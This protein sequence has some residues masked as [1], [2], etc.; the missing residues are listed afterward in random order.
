MKEFDTALV[1]LEEDE[2]QAMIE[3][4][5]T[6]DVG[7]KEYTLLTNA[8]DKREDKLAKT[9]K[10]MYEHMEKLKEAEETA[11]FRKMELEQ[12][13]AQHKRE[14]ELKD[15]QYKAEMDQKNEQFRMELEQKEVQH[16]EEM[17]QRD[18][19]DKMKC[20]WTFAGVAITAGLSIATAIICKKMDFK[21]YE[22]WMPELMN[23]EKEDTFTYAA[24]KAMERSIL[25]Q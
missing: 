10:V 2:L 22:H 12:K 21:N 13:E 15:Q 11:A 24:S 18:R 23:F 6:L 1:E 19:S 8:V 14:I 3:T 25:K 4:R 20:I 9:Y 7:S 5:Q 17:E 16:K